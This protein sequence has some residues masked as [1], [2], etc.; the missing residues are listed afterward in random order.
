MRKIRR[1][2]QKTTTAFVQ[3]NYWRPELTV[4]FWRHHSESR[5][6][7]L[8][9]ADERVAYTWAESVRMIDA[10]AHGLIAAGVPQDH[11]LLIQA[12]NSA[13]YV[14]LRLACE[15]AGII[16]AFL[17]LG[18]R[19]SEIQAIAKK[20]NPVGAI[21]ETS[22]KHNLLALYRTLKSELCFSHLFSMET[23][24]TQIPS[25]ANLVRTP[26]PAPQSSRSV[27]PY[28]MTG[29]VTSSGTT[30]FPKCIEYSCWP[31][32]ASGRVYIERL[33]IT[34]CDTILTCIPFYTGGG[35]MQFH[36]APQVGASFL[37][38]SHFSPGATCSWI[39]RE[40]I[41]G[42]VMVPTMIARIT[43]LPNLNEYDFSSLRWVVSGGGMLQYDIGARFED[44]TGAKIIQGYGLM[45]CG[46]I[47]SHRI[48]D[49]REIRLRS[50]GLLIPG[51]ELRVLDE[52]GCRVPQGTIG[53]IC[54]NG[55]HCNGDY[56]G[57]RDGVQIA[58]RGGF[59]HTGDLG[60]ITD[61]G[62][63]IIEGRSK[64]IIIRGGQNISVHEVLTILCRHPA[65]LDATLVRMP[66]PE[67]GERACA[68]VVLRPGG[69][70]DFAKM[71]AFMKSC[72]IADYKIPERLEIIP[73][74]PMTAGGNKI[75]KYALEAKLRKI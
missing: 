49:P 44:A 13:L 36:T 39:A 42:A 26:T 63:V 50:N 11:V 10:I 17:P 66:D 1:Y 60:R 12:P 52:K 57:D 3:A 32:L 34:D 20:L 40:R 75:D 53:E 56:I 33:K 70:L 7:A 24:T 54:V 59:F 55:P 35:D 73:E 37:V 23:T 30:G 38:Q 61:D 74:F 71:V 4:D 65:I 25:I 28:N 67:L 58:W 47:A 16:P 6:D 48:D 15:E 21:I 29:I 51:V 31:R 8:A 9:V 45:D 19:R 27:R 18:F 64:D 2:T 62:Y 69:T 72:D 46:A 14:L 41:T 43:A 68:F 22:G 5:P